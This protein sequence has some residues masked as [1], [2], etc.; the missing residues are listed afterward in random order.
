MELRPVRA[1]GLESR[2]LLVQFVQYVEQLA[3][4]GQGSWLVLTP[5]ANHAAL[6]YYEHC[7][8]SHATIG[9]PQ[10]VGLGHLAM[11]VPVGKF[12]EGDASEGRTPSPMGRYVVTA[13]AQYL[14]TLLL[15][16]G[17]VD[18]EQGCLLRS[19][20]GKV[21]YVEGKD[22]VLLASVLA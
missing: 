20:S 12:W 13:N 9:V 11:G 2:A 19:T 22:N 18:P 17:V 21:E 8:A 5:M 3:G 7:A 6:V 4:V 1:G 10:V 16:P 15:D 14:G